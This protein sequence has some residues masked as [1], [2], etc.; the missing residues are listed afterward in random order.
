MPWILKHLLDGKQQRVPHE[1]LIN[2]I[3]FVQFD[4]VFSFTHYIDICTA[5]KIFSHQFL[6][7]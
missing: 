1:Y 3:T 6:I 2:V 7:V 4:I 5:L